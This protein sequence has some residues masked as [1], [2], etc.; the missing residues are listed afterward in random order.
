MPNP[1]RR[2]NYFNGGVI[3][4]IPSG[5]DAFEL[6]VSPPFGKESIILYTS[7]APLGNIDLTP[8]G[9]VYVVNSSPDGVEMKTRGVT[10][11]AKTGSAPA[12]GIP[13]EF[14]EAQVTVKTLK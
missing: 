10:I 12:P 14:S 11:A 5:K 13:A 2:D 6:Q 3:Y 1:Y 9:S 8:S 4:E 7:T